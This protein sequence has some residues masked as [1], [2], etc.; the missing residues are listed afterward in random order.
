ML[1]VLPSDCRERGHE[2][3]HLIGPQTRASRRNSLDIF[4]YRSP[5]LLAPVQSLSNGGDTAPQTDPACGNQATPCGTAAT[6]V[7]LSRHRRTRAD[8]RPL[9][10]GLHS[11]WPPFQDVHPTHRR[12]EGVLPVLHVVRPDNVVTQL[13]RRRFVTPSKKSSGTEYTATQEGQQGQM[14]WVAGSVWGFGTSGWLAGGLCVSR[15]RPATGL[16][17]PPLGG[18]LD[19]ANYAPER[20]VRRPLPLCPRG[21]DAGWGCGCGPGALKYKNSCGKPKQY[22]LLLAYCYYQSGQGANKSDR[23][24]V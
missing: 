5:L 16:P 18:R 6:T 24:L 3:T 8:G 10:A 17:V 14:S 1:P 23:P 15:M 7:G 4:L 20:P 21:R 19:R 12:G 22:L 13:T 9:S 11:S 2:S